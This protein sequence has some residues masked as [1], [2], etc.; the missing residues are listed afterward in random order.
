MGRVSGPYSLAP[1]G[2]TAISNAHSSPDEGAGDITVPKERAPKVEAC[3][4]RAAW[5]YRLVG[6]GRTVENGLGLVRR[7]EV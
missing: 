3:I 2:G 1:A 5:R 6:A 4:R 7:T